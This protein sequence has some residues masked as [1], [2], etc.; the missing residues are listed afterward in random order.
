LYYKL[1]SNQ[2]LKLKKKPNQ[3]NQQTE[4]LHPN[5]LQIIFVIESQTNYYLFFPLQQVSV[6]Q[7][8]LVQRNSLG[9]SNCK[10]LFCIYQLLKALE[11][12]H[13]KGIYHGGF[14]FLIFILSFLSFII[15]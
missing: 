6:H 1:S 14:S 15:I 13:Q 7:L 5:L 10:R 8:L 3:E 2:K 4:F 11:Y 12:L 9:K